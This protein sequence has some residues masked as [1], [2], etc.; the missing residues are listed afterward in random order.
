MTGLDAVALQRVDHPIGEVR[1]QGQLGRPA[2]QQAILLGEEG[3]VRAGQARLQRFGAVNPQRG[4]LRAAQVDPRQ[5]LAKFFLGDGDLLG[6]LA[7]DGIAFGE[8]APR[9][10]TH[11]P[12][13]EGWVVTVTRGFGPPPR[14]WA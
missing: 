4:P 13:A 8:V 1:R 2:H 11:W 6:G 3:V 12:S 7:G 5:Q 10:Q 14:Q 9:Y